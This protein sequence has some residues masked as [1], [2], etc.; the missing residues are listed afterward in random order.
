[1]NLDVFIKDLRSYVFSPDGGYLFGSRKDLILKVIAI[2][3][4][5]AVICEK[6]ENSSFDTRDTDP[7][8]KSLEYLLNFLNEQVVSEQG[9]KFIHSYSTLL[10][11]H[12]NNTHK[13]NTIN[14]LTQTVNRYV[15]LR[16]TT[17]ELLQNLKKVSKIIRDLSNI[18]FQPVQLSKHYLNSFDSKNNK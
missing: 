3:E 15:D 16:M 2:V 8:I 17:V 9:S 13:S 10:Y 5:D 7:I 4:R 12:N 14:T 1:M 11:N 18:S 6:E